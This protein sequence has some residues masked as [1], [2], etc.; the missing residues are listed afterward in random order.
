MFL[1]KMCV[2]TVGAVCLG[3]QQ[4]NDVTAVH[5]RS[6]AKITFAE[7]MHVHPKSLPYSDHNIPDS[8]KKDR[9]AYAD[10]CKSKV[11]LHEMLVSKY[12]DHVQVDDKMCS[13]LGG[14]EA[15]LCYLKD[16]S[17]QQDLYY[18]LS[19]VSDSNYD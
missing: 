15:W 9:E 18:E 16:L 13:K 10:W 12:S 3:I 5:K 14:E 17:R 6:V 19:G 11:Q 7:L 1:R 2:G 4:Y 8:I